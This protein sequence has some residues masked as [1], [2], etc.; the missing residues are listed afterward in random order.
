MEQQPAF[1]I[2]LASKSNCNEANRMHMGVSLHY[3]KQKP[4]QLHCL[5]SPNQLY[6][7][8]MASFEPTILITAAGGNIGS[9]LVP[10]LSQQQVKLV[11]PTSNATRLQSRL[12]PTP[13]NVTIEEGSIRDSKWVQSILTKHKVNTVFLCLTSHDELIIALNF[14]DA[15]LRAGTVEHLVYVSAL[16]DFATGPGLQ[17]LMRVQSAMHVVV[18]ATIEQKLL[19]GDFPWTWTVLGPSLFFTNDLRSK[20]SMLKD[21]FFDEPLGKAGVSRIS[22]PD[23]A[24][25]ARNALLEPQSWKGKKVMLGS[26]RC[27]TG[28]ES[29]A[30]W[31]EV[32]GRPVAMEE[33]YDHYEDAYPQW[34][35]EAFG[36]DAEMSKA[37]ER[38]LRLMYQS[39]GKHGFGMTEEQ[40]RLQVEL[41][42]KEPDDYVQWVKET[43]SQWV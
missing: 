25:A 30:L 23:I 21:G 11:L 18:K 32:L 6:P 33:S 14:F 24:L 41:L 35:R 16:G 4:I 29:A 40:N 13:S 19:Y 5:Q 15:M 1:V 42:G 20:E 12:S 37:W 28:A 8:T 39:F 17:E 36:L 26:L 9:V 27:F 43:G 3:S 10:A 22:V 31:A 38:D 2:R 7:F 34:K